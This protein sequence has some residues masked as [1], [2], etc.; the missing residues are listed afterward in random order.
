MLFQFLCTVMYAVTKRGRLKLLLD[1][2]MYTQQREGQNH[3]VWRCCDRG[4]CAARIWLRK[5][6]SEKITKQIPHS[7]PPD[8]QQW[9]KA[10]QT[11]VR[12][13]HLAS[14]SPANNTN[15]ILIQN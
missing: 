6:P 7:H 1:G 15:D 3:F 8:W 11:A 4:T 10:T 13:P 5:L 9:H 2:Y 14:V 12:L